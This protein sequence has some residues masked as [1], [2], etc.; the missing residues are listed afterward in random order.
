MDQNLWTRNY[1]DFPLDHEVFEE[2]EVEWQTGTEEYAEIQPRNYSSLTSTWGRVLF[3]DF[4]L[5]N[6][7]FNKP[8]SE[9]ENFKLS[10]IQ[11]FKIIDV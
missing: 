4:D 9:I 1:S 2:R 8:L 3:E 5:D 11:N 6:I 10:D 7:S